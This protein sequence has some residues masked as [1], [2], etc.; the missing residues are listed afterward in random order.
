MSSSEHNSQ[1]SPSPMTDCQ[2][3][4]KT[5]KRAQR[6]SRAC[7]FCHTRSIRCRPNNDGRSPCQSCVEYQRQCTYDRP[8]KKR[9]VKS[10]AFR[11][12]AS[13]QV[14]ATS[15]LPTALGPDLTCAASEALDH[16]SIRNL[17]EI[18]FE[19]IYPIFPLFHRQTLLRRI[20]RREYAQQAP[21]FA[22]VQALSALVIARVRDGA[23]FSDR[24]QADLVEAMPSSSTVAAA[25][26]LAIPLDARAADSLDY[27]RAVH[28]LALTSMQNGLTKDMH[29]WV[30]V[31]HML[32]RVNGLRDEDNWP[33][34]LG[35]IE[36]EERR[37]VFW[38]MY[39][40]EVFCGAVFDTPLTC[41][42]AE[43]KVRYPS[44]LDDEWLDES[45]ARQAEPA[46]AGGA[47]IMVPN[48][49]TQL[50]WIQGWNFI[51]D[52]YRILEHAINRRREKES[53]SHPRHVARLFTGP[54]SASS[55]KCKIT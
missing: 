30:G 42:E 41:R 20:D 1:R 31:Y 44:S 29:M 53:K 48:D 39:N 35:I 10:N 23:L 26:Q 7:D 50:H 4:S 2:R 8:S 43:N 13:S 24:W 5:K 54:Y 15:A 32:V 11:N 46:A 49:P 28:L 14:S 33:V 27:L 12:S 16:D 9:G 17:A 38:S 40:L 22:C 18:Y 36:L 51:T 55:G 6:V 3:A 45:E 37:R 19:T 21:F 52:L 34:G 47:C 25:A